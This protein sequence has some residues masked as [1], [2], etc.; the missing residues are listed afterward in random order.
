MNE[1]SIT[2][3]DDFLSGD[4]CCSSS[5]VFDCSDEWWSENETLI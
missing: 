5:C 4:D 1:D 2:L 3:G